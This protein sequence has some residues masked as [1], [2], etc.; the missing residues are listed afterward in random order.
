MTDIVYEE[1]SANKEYRFI[2]RRFGNLYKVW[3][4]SKVTDDYIGAEWSEYCPIADYTHIADT[5][6]RAVAIG[7][8]CMNC[9]T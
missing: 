1:Y 2:V 7:K 5:L 8:E 3:L 6:E 4:E 9:F